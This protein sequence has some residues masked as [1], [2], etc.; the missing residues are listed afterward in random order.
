[1]IGMVACRPE[2]ALITPKKPILLS[3]GGGLS[4]ISLALDLGL[5]LSLLVFARVGVLVMLLP[6]L[7][8]NGIPTRH[9]GCF[10]AM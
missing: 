1:M 6:A 2:S 10:C 8:K 9:Y 4:G 3:Q 7:A 5:P